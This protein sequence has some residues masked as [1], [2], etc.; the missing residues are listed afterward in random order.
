MNFRCSRL[1]KGVEK[2]K[3]TRELSISTLPIA[4]GAWIERRKMSAATGAAIYF[5][6]VVRGDEADEKISA[7]HYESE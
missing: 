5:S 1:F 6:G 2:L 4:E 7:I 3:M